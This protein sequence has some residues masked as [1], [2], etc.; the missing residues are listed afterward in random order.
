MPP[1][2]DAW[3][4]Q[5]RELRITLDEGQM[6]RAI[7]DGGEHA[8]ELLGVRRCARQDCPECASEEM[9]ASELFSSCAITR[10]TFFQVATSCELISR[11]SCLSSSSRCG[12]AFSRKRRCDT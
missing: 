9:G 2:G 8:D 7:L 10:I 3:L 12:W 4:R 5:L 11:V 6:L 1:A